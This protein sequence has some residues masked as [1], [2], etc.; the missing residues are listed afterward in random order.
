[1]K[2]NGIEMPAF[3]ERSA[4]L[5]QTRALL[6]R[7]VV[8][9]VRLL[10]LVIVDLEESM[11]NVDIFTDYSDSGHIVSKW[12][13]NPDCSLLLLFV[14]SNAYIS[15]QTSGILHPKGTTLEDHGLAPCQGRVPSN[16]SWYTPTKNRDLMPA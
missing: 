4:F 12:M 13:I 11:G 3:V 15:D 16:K 5:R 9:H 14:L 2:I 1:M 10:K 6:L 7:N 8:L